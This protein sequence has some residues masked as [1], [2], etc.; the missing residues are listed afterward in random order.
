MDDETII[1]LYF[2]RNEEAIARTDAAYGTRLLHISDNILHSREDAREC[3]NDTYLRTWKSI[4]PTR[5]RSLYSFLAKICRNLSLT[6]LDWANA[7]KRRAEVVSLTQEM[8]QCIPAVHR[9]TEPDAKELGRAL[10]TFLGTLSP[11]NRMIFVRRYWYVETTAEIAARYGIRE[12]ALNTRLHRLR[13]K[14]ADYLE[15]EGIAV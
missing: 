10:N 6:R 5:P 8:E 1:G 7:A 4:P 3:V 12:G 15:Q 11:E 2:A 13:N 14:L 9:D